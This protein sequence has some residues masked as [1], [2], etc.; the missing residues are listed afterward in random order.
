MPESLER[1]LRHSLMTDPGDQAFL[2]DGLPAD[3]A[4]LCRIIQG[5]LIHSDWLSAYDVPPPNAGASSRETLPL[6]QRLRRIIEAD[7]GPL[8]VPR[9]TGG[10]AVGTCRDYAVMLC[11]MLRQQHVPARVRCGFAAYLVANRWEDHWLCEY[12]LPT[13]ARWRR[14]DA[15][16]DDVLRQRLGI[17]FD[18]T[19]MPPD[20]FITAGEAWRQCRAGESNPGSFGHGTSHGLWFVR[21]NVMRDHH[22]LNQSEVSAW[23]SWRQAVGKHE[24]VSDIEQ[25]ATDRIARQPEAPVENVTPAW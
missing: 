10:R 6:A 16:L 4:A 24:F 8:T 19:D 9:A 11:G 23:D 21:V 1:W 2:L 14:V 7:P 15:Q 12:R 18:T 13:E 5:L 3:V 22:A 20:M 17:G 25:D